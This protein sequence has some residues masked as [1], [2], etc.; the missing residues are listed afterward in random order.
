MTS[1]TSANVDRRR[2]EAVVVVAL[3]LSVIGATA[4]SADPPPAAAGNTSHGFLVDRGV[5]TTID[6]PK[7]TTIP[8]AP[9]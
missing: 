7:A 8:A 5:V 4:A 6:H 1:P 2:V 3:T 9:D